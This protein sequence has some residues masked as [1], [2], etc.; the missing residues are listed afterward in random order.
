MELNVWMDFELCAN[1]AIQCAEST[2]KQ[3]RFVLNVGRESF[4]QIQNKKSLK[5][6][7][8]IE[9]D[10]RESFFV[11][12]YGTEN[13]IAEKQV[14]EKG[15][16]NM[17]DTENKSMVIIETTVKK[18]KKLYKKKGKYRNKGKCKLCKFRAGE[19]G[20][21]RHHKVAIHKETIE[22]KMHNFKTNDWQEYKQHKIEEHSFDSMSTK[23]EICDK[24]FSSKSNCVSHQVVHQ[25]LSFPC[26]HCG[27]CF[28]STS[29]LKTHSNISHD[30]KHLPC[31][32]CG[33]L[34]SSVGLLKT[35]EKIIHNSAFDCEF[36]GKTLKQQSSLK[37]H[38][39]T[40]HGQGVQIKSF[41]CETCSKW[42][43][44]GSTLKYH[45]NRV[46]EKTVQF[47][48]PYCGFVLSHKSM[49]KRHSQRQHEGKS[50]P[51]RTFDK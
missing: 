15:G 3:L 27:K 22:C 9:N 29:R 40:I 46:H 51:S 28:K 37:T 32:I 1:S 19:K 34:F 23:C 30:T 33:K 24:E 41:H 39:A 7:N 31:I 5:G 49:F 36:C 16:R 12:N 35:H 13:I 42:F 25:D 11:E 38:M 18:G 44:N 4:D 48:C 14:V 17:E 2:I 26:E 43:K 45:V 10:I 21:L 50:L 8:D 20:T 47:I 6:N